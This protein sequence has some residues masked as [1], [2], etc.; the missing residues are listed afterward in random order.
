MLLKSLIN[1]LVQ[2]NAIRPVSADSGFEGV[3]LVFNAIQVRRVIWQKPGTTTDTFQDALHRLLP[4][5]TRVIQNHDLPSTQL[6]A[7]HHAQPQF[8]Q[9][10]MAGAAKTQRSNQTTARLPGRHDRETLAGMTHT[11]VKA[12]LAAH[13]PTALALQTIIA[14]GF[15]DIN[16]VANRYR[17][18]CLDPARSLCL[19][20]LFV[21]PTL[22]LCV[23]PISPKARENDMVLNDTPFS[24]CHALAISPS[25]ACRWR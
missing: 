15:I 1:G 10:A 18:E 14:S 9:A 20:T 13:A 11:P 16:T 8:K 22:F 4:M 17:F 23:Q 19:I 24:C 5:E 2:A 21:T 6:R 12:R 7:Q 3:P 25:V